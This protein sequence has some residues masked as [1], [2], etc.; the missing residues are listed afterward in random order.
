MGNLGALPAL[1]VRPA[2]TPPDALAEF[3][4]VSQIKSQQQ[5]QQMQAQE[6]QVRQQQ[7][8]DQQATTTAMKNWDPASGDY[9][10]L[11]KSVLQNGGSANAATAIQQHGIQVKTAMQG[12]AKGD[13]DAFEAKKKAVGDLFS[14]HT[15][16]PDDQLQGWALN[17]VNTGIQNKLLDPAHA[18]Q[19]QQTVQSTSDPTQLQQKIDQYVKGNLG[20]AA[21]AAQAKTTA[22]AKEAEQKGNEAQASAE[23]KQW[24][25]FPEMGMLYNTKTGETKT[26]SGGVMTPGMLESKYVGL[27]AKQSSG[28]PLAPEDAAF[29]QG[30]EKFKKIVPAFN[31]S[32]GQGLLNDQAKDMAAENYFQ[33]G[34]LPAGARSPGMISSIINRAGELHPG[35]NLAGN[36]VAYEANKASYQ[37]V[38]KTLDTLS[39]F[40]NAGLKNLNQFTDLADKLPDTGVPWANTPIRLLNKDLVGDQWMPAVEAARTVALREIARVTNDPKLSGTL[41]DSA[42]QEVEGLSPTN[43]TMNQIKHV[44]EVLKNDMANV[45]QGLGQQK[46]DIGK[47]L[48]LPPGQNTGETPAQQ[49][50]D[51]Y[52]QFGGKPRNQ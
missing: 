39:A 49:G 7:L 22:E 50:P 31:I 23:E 10:S 42:R 34:Q 18:M 41:T 52:S 3:A 45:H 33:T 8:N 32:M 27:A 36:K 46:Q 14:E 26:V 20:A 11:A 35:G 4:R 19:L 25:K 21:V 28:Q 1:D 24:Q 47:R 15:A 51:F 37:N 16:I 29:M 30:F 44:V 5:A 9:D 17:Q 40:E 43:A 12:L 48:N 38:T 6:M 2:A 13:L